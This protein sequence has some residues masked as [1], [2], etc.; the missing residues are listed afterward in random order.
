MQSITVY[1]TCLP[2]NYFQR[3]LEEAEEKKNASEASTV[4]E[5]PPRNNELSFHTEEMS[6]EIAE[7]MLNNVGLFAKRASIAE[8][9]QESDIDQAAL[10]EGTVDIYWNTLK[11]KFAMK[12]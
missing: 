6:Q 4:P 10:L 11:A 1:N 7:L 2:K 8:E 9:K 12:D 5:K 3:L